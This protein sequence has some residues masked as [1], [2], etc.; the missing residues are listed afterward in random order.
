MI[1]DHVSMA[2]DRCG[3]PVPATAATHHPHAICRLL[4]ATAGPPNRPTSCP[5]PQTAS[6]KVPSGS[7]LKKAKVVE[8]VGINGREWPLKIGFT[9][10]NEL[11][12]GRAAQLGFA[13]SLIG[14]AVTGKGP[15]AQFDFETGT[16][17]ANTEYGLL[18][19]IGFLVFAAINPGSGSF[20]DDEQQ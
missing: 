18:A 9:A 1:L 20:V 13:A 5:P 16:S 2:V 12:V 10:T 7:T 3:C 8:P 19:F 11:F 15:L 14:E 4:R 6:R 17:L